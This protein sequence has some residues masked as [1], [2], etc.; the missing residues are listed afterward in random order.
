MRYIGKQAFGMHNFLA[1]LFAK[2][3]LFFAS[4]L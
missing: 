1:G 3:N 2:V 4:A